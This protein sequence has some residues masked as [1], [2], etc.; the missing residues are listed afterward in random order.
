MKILP[1]AIVI[2]WGITKMAAFNWENETLKPINQSRFTGIEKSIGSTILGPAK[3]EA[4]RDEL[5]RIRAIMWLDGVIVA[6][7]V[8]EPMARKRAVIKFRFTRPAHRGCHA[9]MLLINYLRESHG[10]RLLPS[11]LQSAA[12]AACYQ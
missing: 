8:S 6:G 7:V 2:H 10:I 5:N 3:I 4:F 9:T 11:D 12:G 1:S